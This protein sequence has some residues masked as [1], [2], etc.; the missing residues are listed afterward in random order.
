MKIGYPCINRSLSCRSSRTFRLA[1]YSEKRLYETV[2]ENLQCL[3]EILHYNLDHRIFFFRITSDLIPFASHPVCRA[4]WQSRFADN[5][6]ALGTFIR[7]NQMRISMHPDQ[8]I[9]LNATDPDIVERSK[10][11]LEY[12]A[13]ILDLLGLDLTAKI[14]LHVG[15]VYNDK[16]ASMERFIDQYATLDEPVLRRLVIENDDSRYTANDCLQIHDKTGI[17]ILFDN[18]HH[19]VN[20]GGEELKEIFPAV[21]ATWELHDGI[22]M[23]DYS[24][25]EPGARPGKHAETIDISDFFAFTQDILPFDSDIMLEIKDKEKSAIAALTAVKDDDR[26]FGKKMRPGN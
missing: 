15:G 8:F 14:Q 25:Q 4:D 2:Q 21:A 6:T 19:R 5:F 9:L 23:V 7:I 24:T 16:R 20:S 3:T 1:S 17:P 18:L 22:P 10:K 11:E 12:H 26:L 13:E